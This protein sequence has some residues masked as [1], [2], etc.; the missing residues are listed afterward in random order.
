MDSAHIISA[1]VRVEGTI[2]GDGTLHVAGVVDGAIELAGDVVVEPGGHT[3]GAIHAASVESAG[4]V[5][6]D[7]TAE[8]ELEVGASGHVRGDLTAMTLTIHPDAA[9]TGHV[10]MRLDL[11]SKLTGRGSGRS[12]R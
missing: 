5:D 1:G 9:V 7:V 10:S 8:R 11:P 6:G 3:H 2:R 12:R 4:V